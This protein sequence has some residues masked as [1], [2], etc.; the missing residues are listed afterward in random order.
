M[1]M[2]KC[3]ICDRRFKKTEHFKRH[4][5]SHT[6]E[7]PYECNV[8]HK[9]FSRSDVLSRHAKGHNG[10]AAHTTTKALKQQPSTSSA[11]DFQFQPSNIPEDD[12]Q[13]FPNV[14]TG[15]YS[16]SI[17]AQEVE[18]RDIPITAAAGLA[19][20]LDFLADVSSQHAR[21]ELDAN[22]MLVGDQQTYFG[23]PTVYQ[24]SYRGPV[25]DPVPNESLQ[26]WLNPSDA[27]SY[28]G[29]LDFGHDSN[30]G[31][32]EENVGGSMSQCLQRHDRP[33][34]DTGDTKAGATIPNDRFAKVQNCWLG[35]SNSTGRL[36][37]SIW[38]DVAY[39]SM[40]NI[41]AAHIGQSP[42]SPPVLLQKSRY[43]LDEDCRRHLHASYGYMRLYSQQYRTSHAPP[44]YD[45]ALIALAQFPPA[46]ILDIALDLY[47]C[48]F[49]PLVPFIHLP[50]FSAKNTNSSVLYVMCLIGMTFLGTQGTA[51]FVSKNFTFVL[52]KLTAELA[53]CSIDTGSPRNTMSAFAA[54]ALFLNLAALT[55]EK[56]HIEKSQM[57]YVNLISV[58]QRHGLFSATEGQLLDKSMFENITDNVLRWKAWSKVES[59]KRLIIAL[60]VLDAWLSSF[61]STSPII[62][63]DTIQLILPCSEV[64][65]EAKNSTQWVQLIYEGQCM[66]MPTV[67]SP[68]ENVEI[69]SL[70][71]HIDNFGLHAVLSMVQ[72]RLSD[73]YHRLLSNR[74][75]YP[76]APCHT[77]AMDGRARCL[78]NLQLQIASKNGCILRCT[79]PNASILWHSMCMN[80]T[81]D[82]Q[83]F[84]LAAG[85][86]GP[87]PARKALDNIAAWSQTPAARRA[88]LHAAHVYRIMINRKAS[89]HITFHSVFSLFSAALVLGLYIYLVPS[90]TKPQAGGTPIDI[91]DDID[92]N[93]LCGEGFTS[94][95]EPNGA[96]L[97]TESDEAAVNFIR[98]GG[99]VYFRGV[100]F[101]NGYHSARRI[102]LDYA[103]LLKD[104]GKWSVRKFS[105]VLY[106]MSDVLMDMD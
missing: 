56:G 38:R 94:F 70:D 26:L 102:L 68:S 85:R 27:T 14:G 16:N 22:S 9:R 100:P 24:P 35:P 17:Q 83:I 95:M 37:N 76:F 73:A 4:E 54:A 30:I 25:F 67:L 21:T 84:E 18:P 82:I 31:L 2:K 103:G 13:F 36:I 42:S 63:S 105:H 77:Y 97:C 48:N 11:Q 55:G 19:S 23:E 96:H 78:S 69:A 86:A 45:S 15:V 66:L 92:W 50:T 57:L 62:V 6:K 29:S 40:D 61:L 34:T 52:E 101:Q 106:I 64:L 75:N 39:G 74:A 32:I 72:L 10:P 93:S 46:E 104:T 99:T 91:L 3:N 8:C 51:S 80:L 81:A 79:D 44:A 53:M 12:Q 59:V 28:P 33:S 89:D 65:F 49:H 71:S 47:F 20:S 58:A 1:V 7:K 98:E 87:G 5:R 88:C 41:F 43:G 60:L 90:S